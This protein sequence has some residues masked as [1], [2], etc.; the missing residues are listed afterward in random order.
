[1]RRA[2]TAVIAAVV[3]LPVVALAHPGHLDKNSC[4]YC[5]LDCDLYGLQ[6]AEYH[7]HLGADRSVAFSYQKFWQLQRLL[8]RAKHPT[9]REVARRLR[10]REERQ[11]TVKSAKLDGCY[12]TIDPAT[13]A[14]RA[15]MIPR[16]THLGPFGELL[17]AFACQNPLVTVPLLTPE[18]NVEGGLQAFVRRGVTPEVRSALTAAGFACANPEDPI[19]CT[20]WDLED[21]L[22]PATAL[23][24]LLSVASQLG[25]VSCLR[26]ESASSSAAP[27]S[28]SSL[29]V[30]SSVSAASQ[31]S[32][33]SLSSSSAVSAA[34]SLSPSSSLPAS[35]AAS[36]FGPPP[37]F[38]Q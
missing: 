28:A 35:S 14:E 36:S 3:A 18:L 34:S 5:T 33:A 8:R 30:Q 29:P 4:H 15:P 22:V 16:Y 19:S 26:C 7:C 23:R 21:P 1:M 27:P 2:W 31:Q 37:G 6:Y 25:R 32:S 13:G 24:P 11:N 20:V 12:P 9:L 10:L 17:T 38:G